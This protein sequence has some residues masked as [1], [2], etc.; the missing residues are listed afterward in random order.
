MLHIRFANRDDVPTILCFIK[1]LAEFEKLSSEVSAT[2]EALTATLFAEPRRAEVLIAEWQ[3]GGAIEA[4]GFAL[5]FHNYSTF[6]AKPGLYLE[7]LYVTEAHRS[8]GVGRA[9][10]AKLAQIALERDCGR[11]EWWV[12]DWNAKAIRFYESLGAKPMSEWTVFRVDGAELASL[13]LP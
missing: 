2:E 3:H 5:F 4:A 12:L 10:L 13:A 8:R 6:L 11:L 9:L 1:A 7:D